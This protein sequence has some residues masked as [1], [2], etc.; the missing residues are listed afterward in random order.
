MAHLSDEALAIIA[1]A[2]PGTLEQ[3]DKAVLA[4]ETGTAVGY[5]YGDDFKV[6]IQSH[7]NTKV[8][9][10]FGINQP[11]GCIA[12]QHNGNCWHR[13]AAD[14]LYVQYE[15]TNRENAEK[16]AAARTRRTSVK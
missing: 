7:T 3:W 5:T 1:V 8:T 9:Y 2:T 6:A 4:V 14:M 11:C 16:R 12:A 15:L 10:R 13:V